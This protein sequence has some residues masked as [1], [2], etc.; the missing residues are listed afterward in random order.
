MAGGE[1]SLLLRIKTAGEEALKKAEESF[2][3]LKTAAIGAF[4]IISAV[5]V[6]SIA[7]YRQS[8]VATNALTQSMVNNGIYSKQLKNDYLDQANALAKLSL[9][10]DEEIV[11]AQAS[12]QSMI[13]QKKIT[14]E[15]TT[16]IMDLA[17][18]KKMDLNSAAELVGKTIAGN[19]NVLKRQGVEFDNNTTGAERLAAV[20]QGLS[21]KFGGQAQAATGGLGA[22]QMMFKSVSELSESL[23]ERLAPFVILAS[24]AIKAFTDDSSKTTP[25]LDGFANALEVVAAITIQAYGYIKQLGMGIGVGL[26]AAV[27]SA[28]KA[29][30][31][32]FSQALETV[33]LGFNTIKEESIKISTETDAALTA[34]AEAGN[35]SKKASL[36]ADENNLR[37]SLENKRNLRTIMSEEEKAK[38]LTD[39]EE[40]IVQEQLNADLLQAQREGN[41][42]KQSEARLKNLQNMYKNEDDFHKK[43]SLLEAIS[44]EQSVKNDLEKQKFEETVQKQ[45]LQGFSTFFGGIASLSQS[46]NSQLAAIGKAGAISQ[47]TIDAYLAIQN[48]LATV[49]Y[50]ANL[51][52]AAGI[53]IT[54]FA[55]VSKIAGIPLAEGGIVKARPGGIQ[56]T[57]GES[58]R[59]E[60]V[61]PLENGQIPGSNSGGVTIN[62]YGGLLGDERSA[63]EFAGA[64]D[65]ELLKLRQN[66]GSV[67]FDRIS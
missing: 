66:G 38:A 31:G 56:A 37:Q 50:P 49:P 6:K 14:P 3:S 22:M 36:E 53:G 43:K 21:A 60:A 41:D 4:A 51:A 39:F 30:Q 40:Q 18:A 23:G 67:A 52:T 44:K 64:V 42:L 10:Q 15:L 65:R 25:I 34:L 59:D 35:E 27:E 63:Q 33:K 20:T 9:Y 61:I 46:S 16:A 47:A 45:R 19:T 1:A 58:G 54:A 11:S 17:T 32:N 55:N 62:V 5:V 24:N 29:L 7:D 2:D 28:S 57:I 26:A 8:E 12:L 48:A 13:G